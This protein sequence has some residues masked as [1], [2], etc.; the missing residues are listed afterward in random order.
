MVYAKTLRFQRRYNIILLINVHSS[1]KNT[2]IPTWESM[3][4]RKWE[5]ISVFIF[6][7]QLWEN[8]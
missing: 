1:L 4:L 5:I 6:A 3:T 7:S 2:W 8:T